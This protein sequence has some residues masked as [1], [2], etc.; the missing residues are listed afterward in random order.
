IRETDAIGHVVRCFENDNIVHVAGRVDPKQDIEI[1][2]TELALADLDSVEKA[3]LR[4]G[5]RAKGGDVDAKFELKVLEKLVPQLNEGHLLRAMDLSKEEKAAISYM[6][7]L[8][9]KPIMYIANV[10]EDGFDN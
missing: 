1:I 8:T 2:D 5:K 9:L 3:I 7:L 10:N 4:V 6:N